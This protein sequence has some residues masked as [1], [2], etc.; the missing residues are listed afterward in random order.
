MMRS[1][2]VQETEITGRCKVR[3]RNSLKVVNGN[4]ASANHDCFVFESGD[5][6]IFMIACK[7]KNVL[8][9]LTERCMRVY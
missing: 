6:E 5:I 1:Q 3:R 7:C 2:K 4:Q 8:C 9:Q